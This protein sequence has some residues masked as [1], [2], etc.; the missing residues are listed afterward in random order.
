[1]ED[2]ILKIAQEIMNGITI[3]AP[4]TCGEEDRCA[5]D[6]AQEIAIDSAWDH[7]VDQAE[8]IAQ[9]VG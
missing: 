9:D 2:R 4:C 7:A 6:C 3:T 1:M 5:P 8:E